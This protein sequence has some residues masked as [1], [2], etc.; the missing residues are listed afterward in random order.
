MRVARSGLAGE[1]GRPEPREEILPRHDL[2]RAL[3][4]QPEEGELGDG[5]MHRIARQGHLAADPVDRQIADAA[6][7]VGAPVRS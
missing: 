6:T 5:E 2:A 4:Q 3:D 7:V 1:V